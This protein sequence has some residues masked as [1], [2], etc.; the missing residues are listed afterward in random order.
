MPEDRW[1]LFERS[2]K[3]E[4]YLSYR[5]SVGGVQELQQDGVHNKGSRPQAAEHRGGGYDP[6]DLHR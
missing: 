2:G 6:H 3:I 4:D 5:Q 1:V